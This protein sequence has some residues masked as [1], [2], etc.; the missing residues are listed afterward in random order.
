MTGFTQFWDIYKESFPQE[1][2]R[3]MDDYSE[4][5]VKD[6]HYKFLPFFNDKSMIG[7]VSLWD[8][9]TFLFIEHFAVHRKLRGNG[10]GTKILRKIIGSGCKAIEHRPYA[11]GSNSQISGKDA[12][13]VKRSSVSA[14]NASIEPTSLATSGRK[15]GRNIVL[16]VEPRRTQYLTG[17]LSFM[18]G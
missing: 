1:E 2:R 11:I 14:S 8:L 7:F 16:E 3:D 6:P 10:Y 15:P 5:L 9:D 4:N 17:G 13:Q 12:R 18:R